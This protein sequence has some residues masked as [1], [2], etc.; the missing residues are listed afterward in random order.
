MSGNFENCENRTVPFSSCKARQLCEKEK[1]K[2][3]D[4]LNNCFFIFSAGTY[5]YRDINHDDI[6][7]YQEG[8]NSINHF[9]AGRFPLDLRSA[10]C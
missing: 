8:K 4:Y 3:I 1:E 9:S 7:T 6:T 2:C 10:D 5:L